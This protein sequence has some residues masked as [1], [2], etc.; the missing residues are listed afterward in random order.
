M[1][2]LKLKMKQNFKRQFPV[3]GWM[4]M[5]ALVFSGFTSFNLQAQERISGVVKDVGGMPLPGVSIIQKGTTRGASTDFDGN[6]NLELTLGEKTLVFSYL[7]FKTVEIPVAGKTTINVNLE[8][9]IASLDEVVIVGYGTQKKESVVAAITQIKGED[10]MERTMGVANVEQALQGNLPGVTAIQGSGVP[11]QDNMR[12][13]IRGRSSWNGNGDPLVLV[14]GVKRSMSDLDMNDIENISV[15]KDGSATAVFGVEGA[16]GVILITTKRGQVGKAELSFTANT[17][18]KMV[19]QLPEK[20]DSYDGL[21][22]AN[23]AILR[24]VAQAPSTWNNYTPLPIVE[25]YRNPASLEESYIYPNVDWEE[26]LLKDFAQDYR[27][28]LSVRGGN[29]SAKYFG[30]LAYQTVSD[31]FD[32]GKYDNGRGYLGEYRYDRF[33]F[34]S[35][36]D[37][38]I[39]NTTEL[40]VSLAGFL[41]IRENPG[42]IGNVTNGLYLIAPSLYPPVY[43]DGLYGNPFSYFNVYVN[44]VQTLQAQGYDTFRTFTVNSD[45]ILKQKLDFITEGLSFQGRFSLDNT[46]RSRQDLN[47]GGVIFRVYDGDQESLLFP[48]NN[49]RFGYVQQPWTLDTSEV[50]NNQRS[51]QMVYDFSFNYDRS[52]GEKHNFT[53]LFLVRRQEQATGSAFPRYREDW[54]GR[55]TYNYDSRYFLDING[56][57]NGSEKFGPGF[58]FDLF[59]SL[60]A[61]WTVS[62]EAFMENVDWIDNLKFRGSY[63][64]VGDDNFA[65][66]WRYISQWESGQSGFLVPSTYQGNNGRSPY[67]FYREDVVGNPNLQWESATKYNVGVDFSFFNR[68]LTGEVNYFTEDRDNIVV[69]GNQIQTLPDFFGATPPDINTG[70]TEIR[71]FEIVLGT[72]YTFGNGLNL[73]G[74]FNFSQAIDKVIR[75]DDP[76]LQPDY[77]KDAGF[78]IGQG[79]TAI[80]AGILTSWDDVYMSTPQVQNQGLTRVGYYDV[81]D[82]DGDGIYNNNFD[83]A[84]FGYP[85]QPQRTWAAT[86]GARYKGFNISA[87]LYGT[88]NASRLFSNN[89]FSNSTPLIFTQDLDYWTVDTPNN[90]DT[91]P[92]FG[93]PGATN[94]RDNWLDASLT[95]LRAVTLSYDIPKKTCEK[96]GLKKLQIFANGNNLFLW[97]NMPDDREFNTGGGG[98]QRGDYPTLKSFNFGFNMNF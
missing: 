88:Q 15:L 69:V 18:M 61:G 27:V 25:R 53:G 45:F 35:N 43:P 17:T 49:T 81:V 63:A 21:L 80:P 67:T 78:N 82:F 77:L 93:V 50:E 23:S 42:S 65:G 85:N 37:F 83:N 24:G 22:E 57:Y 70:I 46:Q 40:S 44:P 34:R 87:Q 41:G 12:I 59:P 56:A 55:V 29:K 26:E 19:S 7:G 32:G 66:R 92:S 47:D 39:T 62:N 95:R 91:Q 98:Q 31:I 38:N 48:D 33:N 75:R 13:F 60:A 68:L 72:N 6:Y 10:L 86:L 1:L 58:R 5:L 4:L 52:F 90:T 89:T 20:L 73:Y 8:E 76:F 79:R 84:P 14:D 94:P 2:K 30:S 28:N 16:N 74:D 11:G 96:L 9:D 71:G 54:V 97:S 36:I 3:L 64:I 51:R